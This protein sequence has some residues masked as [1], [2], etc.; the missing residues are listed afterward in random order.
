M[1]VEGRP[2]N[3][4]VERPFGRE[5]A[6]SVGLSGMHVLY[7]ELL[8]TLTRLIDERLEAVERC[9]AAGKT[10]H[11]SGGVTGPGSD[12][13]DTVAL[14][15]PQRRDDKRLQVCALDRLAAVDRQHAI[16]PGDVV[17]LAGQKS[18]AR[19]RFESADYFL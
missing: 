1:A 11:H 16:G 10:R 3:N 5:T 15:D 12:L 19:R 14:F 2:D 4:A 18:G 13:Q 7:A 6:R 9:N 17:K 8:E